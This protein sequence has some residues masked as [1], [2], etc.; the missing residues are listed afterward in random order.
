M[1]ACHSDSSLGQPLT[2]SLHIDHGDRSTKLKLRDQLE[3]KRG[4]RLISVGV[5]VRAAGLVVEKVPVGG[6]ASDVQTPLGEVCIQRLVHG[7]AQCRAPFAFESEQATQYRDQ[8]LRWV[9]PTSVWDGQTGA[10]QPAYAGDF[11]LGVGHKPGIGRLLSLKYGI[12]AFCWD[13]RLVL[14]GEDERRILPIKNHHIDLLAEVPKAIHHMRL[15]RLIP[16]GKIGI[17]HVDPDVLTRIA[18]RTRVTEG[19]AYHG[20]ALLDVLVQGGQ[21]L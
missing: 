7:R 20:Q 16:F 5:A 10:V 6:N 19:L 12:H 15:G 8:R 2:V 11:I 14:I 1:N 21:E 4:R 3:K 9:S 18:L 17:Q 13:D